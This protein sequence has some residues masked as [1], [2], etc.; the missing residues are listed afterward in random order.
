M[1]IG[2]IVI[3]AGRK[4]I[5]SMREKTRSL[6][7]FVIGKLEKEKNKRKKKGKEKERKRSRRRSE[8]TYENKTEP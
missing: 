5:C 8:S 6:Y 3:R 4:G 1:T 2:I 7:K